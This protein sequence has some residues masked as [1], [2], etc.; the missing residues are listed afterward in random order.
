MRGWRVEETAEVFHEQHEL[1]IADRGGLEVEIPIEG[2]R[3]GIDGMHQHCSR[4]D[5]VGCL[6]HSHVGVLQQGTTESFSLFRP[7]DSETGQQENRN[8]MIRE[9]FRS[10]SGDSFTQDTSGSD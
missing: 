9:A 4:T 8:R 10:P 5:N 7:V 6:R 1:Q 2:G 3:F